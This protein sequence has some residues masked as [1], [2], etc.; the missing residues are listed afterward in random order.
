MKKLLAI[1][2]SMLLLCSMIPFATV[3]AAGDYYIELVADAEEVDAGDEI[4][5][6]VS[7]YGHE[8]VGLTGA[9]IEL[10]F[11]HDVFELV[12]TYDEDEEM[13][14]PPIEVAS[15]FNAS[16]NKYILFSPI[17]EETGYM[18]R[19]LVQFLRATATATQAVKTNLFY[20]VTFKVKDDAISGDYTIQVINHN[21]KNIIQRGMSAV[22]W[23]MEPITVTVNGTEPPHVCDYVASETKAPTCGETGIMTYTCACGDSYTEIIPATGEHV[24]FNDCDII[25]MNCG[26]ESREVAHNV[27]H[28]EAKA[29]TCTEIGNIEHWYCSVC[30][31]AWLDAECTLNT[32]LMAVKLG[33]TCATNAIHTAAVEATCDAPGNVEYWYCA[34]CD[35]YYLDAACTIITNANSVI[36]SV[37]HNVVHVAA[38]D[39]TC[40]ELGNIEY[41][42]CDLC[43]AAWLDEYC[44]LNTNLKAV[45][46]PMSE[47]TYADDMDVDCDICGDVRLVEYVVKSFGGNSI[48]ESSDGVS[49]LAFRYDLT[50]KVS[51]LAIC[52]GTNHVA[53]Y[54]NATVTPNSVGTYK[55]VKMGVLVSNG[56]Q[57]KDVDVEKIVI[58]EDDS[59][60][61]VIRIIGIPDAYLSDMISCTP[62]Y[63]YETAEGEQI[64]V[65][66]ETNEA[67]AADYMN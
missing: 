64:T 57:T 38:K 9:Q 19:C 20:T 53:D 2:L 35:V 28:A 32:N 30:G 43:G 15:K 36:T 1:L 6:E 8:S 33:A 66:G 27:I 25:C 67:C 51:G 13:W 62:Y 10:G 3:S 49:G 24:Y 61:Y 65:T 37:A 18:E 5:V 12:T 41:W 59:V 63:V 14:M 55:L 40:S 42:Y 52:K 26:Q 4:T 31:Q 22:E 34:N 45:I 50:D 46:L 17:D 23:S 21:D 39:A 7:L 11:D 47:H 56:F 44:H 54:S 60:Y 29:P 16:S 58:N 48:A